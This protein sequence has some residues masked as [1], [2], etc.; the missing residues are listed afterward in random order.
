MRKRERA[1]DAR[2]ESVIYYHY[3]ERVKD[4]KNTA[5]MFSP[6]KEFC[7]GKQ[8]NSSC[9]ISPSCTER[10]M[11]GTLFVCLQPTI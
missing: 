4:P 2:N 8:A 9:G 7:S 3:S 11:A 1:L 5:A 10:P 6:R